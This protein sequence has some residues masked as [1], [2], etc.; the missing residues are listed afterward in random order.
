MEIAKVEKRCAELF[1]ECQ[2]N[3]HDIMAANSFNYSEEDLIYEAARIFWT[4]EKNAFVNALHDWMN[5]NKP[6]I[7]IEEAK[8]RNTYYKNARDIVAEK[9][10]IVS[11]TV[12]NW[13]H[14]PN[15]DHTVAFYIGLPIDDELVVWARYKKGII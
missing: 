14:F 6:E 9:V 11:D 13:E 8:Q 5:G 10:S 15:D 7:T 4:R 12:V 2:L 1:G 3:I